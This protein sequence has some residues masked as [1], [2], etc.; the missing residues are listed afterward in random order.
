MN[1][2]LKTVSTRDITEV[3]ELLHTAA[4]VI[5]EKMGKL[6]KEKE[7]STRVKKEPFWKRRLQSSIVQW[8]KYLSR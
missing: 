4:Y 5:C 6:K 1:T 3:N 2:V 8:R 7:K